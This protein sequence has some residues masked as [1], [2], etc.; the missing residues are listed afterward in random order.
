MC[1][2]QNNL[3]VP[4]GSQKIS[5]LWDDYNSNHSADQMD[6]FHK[7]ITFT[8]NKIRTWNYTS[9]QATQFLRSK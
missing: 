3:V 2:N 1:N 4:F 9:E 8:V 7:N 6:Q 5:E